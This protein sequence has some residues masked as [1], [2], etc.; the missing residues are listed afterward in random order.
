MKRLLLA[1]FL[2]LAFG[3]ASRAETFYVSQLGGVVAGG[4]NCNGHTAISAAAFNN[5][6]NWAN[7]KVA[8]KIGPGDTVWL[9]GTI[10]GSANTT[11]LALQNNGLSGFP[12][13]INADSTFIL[14]A[15]FW[16]SSVGG[17]N[18]GG[19]TCGPNRSWIILDGQNQGVVQNT[20]NGSRLAN[21]QAST[22][23]SCLGASNVTIQKWTVSNM[24]IEVAGD[25]G[26]GDGSFIKALDFSGS[27]INSN[28]NI[29]NDCGWC[30]FSSFANGDTDVDFG[31]NTF[32][33]FNHAYAYATTGAN[34]ATNVRIH[35]SDMSNASN[36]QNAGCSYHNDGLHFFGVA[37]SSLDNLAVYNNYFHGPWGPCITGFIFTEGGGS[38]VHVVSSSYYGNVGIVPAGSA[39]NT[40]GWFG[41]FSG[42]GTTK[43][44]NNTIIGPSAATNAVSFNIG[45]LSNLT[46]EGNVVSGF[47][48][49]VNFGN[50]SGT[51]TVNNNYYDTFCNSGNCFIFNGSFK[52]SFSAWKTALAAASVVGADAA[53][54]QTANPFVGADGTPTVSSPFLTAGLNLT[55]QCSSNLTALCTS[56]TRGGSIS[57]PPSRPGL[58]TLW[59]MGAYQISGGGGTPSLSFSPSPASFGNQNV[60]TTGSPV[61]IT[62][63]NVGTASQVLSTPYFTIT[64]TNSTNFANTGAGTCANGGTIAA[65]SSC[66]VILTFTPS[67][68]GARTATL[69]IQGTVF[70]TDTLNGTG[71]APVIGLS[72]SPAAFGNQAVST[73]SSPLTVTLSNTG[74]SA[75]VLGTPYFTISGTNASNFA[76][77]GTGSCSN[78]GTIA[79]SG[80]C[81]VNLTFTPSATGSRTATLTVNGTVSAIDS[82]TGTGTAPAVSLNP[83]S[84]AFGNQTVSTSSGNTPVTLTNSGNSTLTITS[85]GLTGANS[86]QFSTNTST[87]GGSLAASASCSLNVVFSP[88]TTGAKTASL[89]FTTNAST[90]PD[91][92]PLTGTGT[93]APVPIVGLSPSP[94]AFGNQLQGTTSGPL[95]ITVSN[96]G[97]ANEVLATPYWTITGTNATNFA[98]LG[99]GSCANGATIAPSSSCTVNL[100][101]T[102]SATGSRTAT[103]TIQGTVNATDVLTGTGT[104]PVIGIS[105]ATVG[106]GN[107]AVNTTSSPITV[108]ISNT[109][110]ASEVLAT[111]YF[112]ITGTNATNFANAGT[113]TCTNGGTI[114]ASSSCTVNLTFTPSGSGVRGAT[115]TL[116]GTVNATAPLVGTGTAAVVSLNP[117]SIAFGNQ[118]TG[119]SSGN[120]LVTLTNTGNATLTITSIAPSGANANQFSTNGSTCG[121][122]LAASSSCTINVVFSPTSIGAKVAALTFTTS[123]ASSP[124]NVVLTG[125]GT[126]VAVPVLSFT[127]SPVTFGTQNVGTTGPTV[128]VTVQNIGTANEVLSSP[129]FTFSGS[130]NFANAGTGSCANGATILPTSTCTVDMTF[131]PSANGA[132][133]GTLTING[134]VNGS[135]QLSGTGVSSST[136]LLN[137]TFINYGNQDDGTS[138]PPTAVTMTNT[139]TGTM[140]ITSIAL[141]GANA[142]EF[143][144]NSST[145]SAT[146]AA[147]ASCTWNV[148]FSPVTAGS[149]SAAVTITTSAPSS[150]DSIPLTG[151][152][153]VPSPP[154]QP[155]PAITI[156][157]ILPPGSVVV[158]AAGMGV[159]PRN[160]IASQLG[161]SQD[162]ITFQNPCR[163]QISCGNCKN[164]TA[165]FNGTLVSSSWSKGTVTVSVPASLIAP[166][167]VATQYQIS[168]SN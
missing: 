65:S 50:L 41:I 40:N 75:Q 64:G 59:D 136:V 25:T 60:G 52:G 164:A 138:S 156:V 89:T 55:A 126:A 111:P 102:P 91:N 112:T 4:T 46:Y 26:I 10:T 121:G 24:Y 9:C 57:S 8:G 113:G 108:T 135:V 5:S 116:L 67:A 32:T 48:S 131:T 107:Q 100:T 144:I 62:V 106:F 155:A 165:R 143:P 2:F 161:C 122:T 27:H 105:P 103:L 142:S 114:A 98:N 119:T 134:T 145:C 104:L 1:A 99:T 78:G 148:V 168:L 147:S 42:S 11:G 15:P 33:A 30:H 74:T 109:G 69:T 31:F 88:T 53:S 36:W 85:I 72:P 153:R 37:G 35:D 56:T 128:T 129:Y 118:T 146:L 151:T 6:A 54:I 150:P 66:T 163:F 19:I 82:L 140:T 44:Y 137:P 45:S 34:A 73:T 16:A 71:T 159:S 166:P 158:S 79:I 152:G 77:A 157:T 28:H 7:P 68:T 81:T 21:S 86:N 63:S 76:N 149:K 14:Q 120:S 123:A 130:T 125:T 115:F 3:A 49:V 47:G 94:G 87:C 127:P 132:I 80:S 43:V 93:P 154:S 18:A 13:T 70:A 29:F 110:T 141:T 124:D 61:T 96:T 160:A 84:I 92:V 51:T 139:G 20:A 38:T 39:T 17:V 117:T 167:A 162:G 101:F 83:V 95:T 58:P 12:I 22:G 133:T 90:S 23:I 97:T